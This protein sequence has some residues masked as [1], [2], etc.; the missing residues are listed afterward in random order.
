MV[1]YNIPATPQELEIF[2]QDA[3]KHLTSL[4][5]RGPDMNAK[6]QS[7]LSIPEEIREK[8]LRK[9]IDEA[10]FQGYSITPNDFPYEMILLKLKCNHDIVWEVDL[11]LP[12]DKETIRKVF[13]SWLSQ[14]NI[15][16]QWMV[17]HN[18]PYKKKS[19]KYIDHWHIYWL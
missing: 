13:T 5:G 2:F 16:P 19:V 14:K 7:Y 8:D 17:L 10:K 1:R 4:D 18:N 11:D 9:E 6:Y 3:F 15:E 12:F